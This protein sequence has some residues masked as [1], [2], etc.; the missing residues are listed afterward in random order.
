VGGGEL[1]Q[2]LRDSH[3]EPP[4]G[5]AFWQTLAPTADPAIIYHKLCLPEQYLS[6]VPG[7]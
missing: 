6:F 4:E 3:R 7:S 1:Q 2:P 5:Q